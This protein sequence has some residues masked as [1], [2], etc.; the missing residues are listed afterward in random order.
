[1]DGVQL[2]QGH[3]HFEEAV[4]FLPLFSEIPGIDLGWMKD[5]VDLGDTKWFWTQDPWIENPAP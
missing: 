1:M 5:C 4:Y 3:N 2:P